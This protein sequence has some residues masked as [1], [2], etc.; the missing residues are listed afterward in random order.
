MSPSSKLEL[1]FERE[2]SL[3]KGFWNRAG[4]AKKTDPR[5]LV[6]EEIQDKRGK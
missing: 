3:R 6:A 2:K 4:G 5:D 1:V